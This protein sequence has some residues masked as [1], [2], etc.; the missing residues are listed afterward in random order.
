[1]FTSEDVADEGHG[2]QLATVASTDPATGVITLTAPLERKVTAI[3][4]GYG[5]MYAVEVSHQC[6]MYP[7]N[8]HS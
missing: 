3:E 5:D 7:N 8:I 4:D 1:M 2:F 6:W